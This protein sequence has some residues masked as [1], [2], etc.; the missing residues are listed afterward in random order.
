[1]ILT[2]ISDTHLTGKFDE[3]KFRKLKQIIGSS[4]KVVLNGDFWDGY[5]ADF[6]DF[7]NSKWNL[8]FPLLK[9]KNAVYV[10][11][12]HDKESFSDER[13]NNFCISA[14]S[15][16]IVEFAG[17]KLIFEH[18]DQY[19]WKIDR[20]LQITRP[21]RILNSI[22]EFFQYL[23]IGIMGL[24]AFSILFGSMNDTLKKSIALDL[25]KDPNA[26]FFFGHVH[27]AE[28]DLANRFVNTGIFNYGYAQYVTVDDKGNVKA[29]NERY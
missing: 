19:V 1:M 25:A 9:S 26:I 14:D 2:V 29:I 8:L 24:K 10:F 16:Q 21:V 5:A 23:L 18:G 20:K 7:Y 11:G 3:N 27:V 22:T 13:R 4:D 28:L 17:K 6:E 12:N 15:K